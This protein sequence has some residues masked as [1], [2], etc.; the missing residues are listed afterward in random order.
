MVDTQWYVA[1]DQPLQLV[2]QV[3]VV[4]CQLVELQLQLE[5]PQQLDV[6][7]LDH[8]A[9]S[10]MTVA[11]SIISKVSVSRAWRLSVKVFPISPSFLSCRIDQDVRVSR[12]RTAVRAL[13]EATSG[14]RVM[15]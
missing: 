6:E 11:L 14:F 5:Q 1:A 10:P 3:E 7:Q 15:S 13:A 2:V 8:A 12:T 9:A 4:E